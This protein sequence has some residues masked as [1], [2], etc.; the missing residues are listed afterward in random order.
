MDDVTKSTP[1]LDWGAS[2]EQAEGDAL[3]LVIVWSRHQPHRIGEVAPIEGRC[4][5]GRGPARPDDPAPRAV[6]FQQRPG[7]MF[8]KPPLVG[9]TLSRCQLELTPLPD[10]TLEVRRVGRCLLV[11]RGQIEEHAIVRPGETLTLSSTL[12]LLVV[13]RPRSLPPLRAY[14]SRPL[15]AF[16]YGEPDD[17]GII[18]ESPAAWALRDQLAFAAASRSHVLVLG[19]SGVGKE[20]AARAIHAMSRH[21]DDPFVTRN[22]ST[23]PEGLVDAELFGAA[24]GY[25]NIGSPERP[26]LLGQANG[27]T[28]FLDE[29]GEMP[30]ELQAHLLRA[31]D[32][33]GEYQRL[34]DPRARSSSFRV[35]AATNRDPDQLKHDFCARFT[36]RVEVPGLPLR[37]EDI[38][39]L[40]RHLLAAIARANPIF[41]ER[42]FERGLGGFLEARTDSSL[43]DGLLR[44]RYTSHTRELERFLSVALTTSPGNVLTL[45][46]ELS[47]LLRFDDPA[48]AP[49][50]GDAD[51]DAIEHAQITAALVATRNNVAKAARRLVLDRYT[52]YRKMRRL[53]IPIPEKKKKPTG[54]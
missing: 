10:G 28:L 14:P 3:H 45:T 36:I 34:G 12:M 44:H 29:I 5:L 24:R 20:L 16:G 27:G 35:I 32:R 30:P 4:V 47:A 50:P 41:A 18:G 43:I 48:P 31:L 19:E 8:P 11:V 21:E 26:G 1:S 17:H 39:F 46:P 52:L 51:P 2:Q 25:P 38:P 6:F 53:G 33:G 37:R 9:S 49:R 22:A 23:F 13:R 40:L 42:F 54:G 7:V 15:I